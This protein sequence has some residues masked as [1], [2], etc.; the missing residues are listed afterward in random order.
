MWSDPRI[1]RPETQMT[2]VSFTRGGYARIGQGV[3][4]GAGGY[5]VWRPDHWLLDGTDLR[6]GDILGAAHTVVGYECDGCAMTLRNGV[7]EPTHEDGCPANFEIVAT[8]PAHLW[9]KTKEHDSAQWHGR[10]HGL[11]RLDL[12]A[13]RRRPDGGADHPDRARPSRVTD[14]RTRRCTTIYAELRPA[15]GR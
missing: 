13:G 10:D 4:R 15:P 2:G 1:G 6:Y 14:G 8:A 7:P 12:R 5:T 9:S 11:H 3:P